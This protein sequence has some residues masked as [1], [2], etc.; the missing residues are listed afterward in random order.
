[1]NAAPVFLLVEPS[2]MLCSSLH[3]WLESVLTDP[4]IFIA[5]SGLEALN[6]A[7]QEKPSHILVE[8]DL[9]DT[10][11]TEIVKQMSQ[12]LPTARIIVTGW[13]DSRLILEIVQSAG[14][15]G[16][17]PKNKLRNE[18]LPLWGLPPR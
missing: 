15:D 7:M 4:R 11:G 2:P 17:I 9:P 3:E 16:F 10:N 18:L 6:L 12:K 13:Y 1:M 8:M 5:E 14:A